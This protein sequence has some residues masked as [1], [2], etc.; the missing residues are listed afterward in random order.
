[1]QIPRL[2]CTQHPDTTVKITASEE[3][4][5]AIVAY[6]AYGCD[7][8]MVDYEGKM[9]P[10]GQ[11]KEI[12]M[13]AIRG[14][15]P[16]GDRFYITVRLPNPKLEEFDR[17]MLSLEA[18]FV[19]NYF[20]RK[21]ADVQAVRWVIL[22]MV[23][24]L[25]T[26]MLVR[27]M[28]KRKAEVYKSETG[29]DVG[30]IEVIP[31]IEDAFVQTKA[32]AIVGEVFKGE[33]AR[34]VRVFL[35]K[36][37]SAVKHGHLASALAI[38]Y[39]MSRLKEFEAESG[40]RVRLILGMGSPPFRGA[41]NN[42]RLAHLEVVQYAGYYTATIQSAVR[43]DTSLDEYIRV[44][45]SILNACC[46]VRSSVSDE[47]LPLIQ[48]ASSK[49]RSQV[50]KHVDKI[51]EVARLVPS[52]RDRVSWKEYGRSL[53]DGERVVHMPRAIVYTSTWYAMGFPPTL[54]D[55]PFLL[56]LAK[57]GRLDA[58]FK[59]LPTYRRELEYDYEF[60]DPQTAR[61]YLGEELVNAA[62]ELAD[63]LGVEARPSP[64]YAAL[65]RMPRSEPNIIALS[66]YRKFLG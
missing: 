26:V 9:T 47:V 44:K 41:I 48:E 22:P 33:E 18:A 32:K 56:E 50:M 46:G 55:A 51:V 23:E 30:D 2:M 65:L 58:V 13:K 40:I 63:Y 4:D 7:E 11:P 62:V 1:M 37:D 49:Y 20:S 5:E 21:Y 27:K 52:T 3:V 36:S 19:A 31:L 15:I 24:D 6:T 29:I 43:Y 14:G 45:E 64:T 38:L 61:R 8:V 34:E 57:S 39:A 53:L 54:I 17:A 59:L 35:G 12:V 42:P 10:Y 16:L 66:K 28:L 25:D 60:F